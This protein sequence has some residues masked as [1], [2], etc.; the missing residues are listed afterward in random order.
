MGERKRCFATTMDHL[1]VRE[2]HFH[3]IFLP[4]ANYRPVRAKRR[5]VV[6]AAPAPVGLVRFAPF[7]ACRGLRRERHAG[8]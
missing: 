7:A 4:Y 1:S 3:E 5:R 2:T 6:Y 8:H